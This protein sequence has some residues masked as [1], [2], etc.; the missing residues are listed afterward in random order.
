M[1]GMHVC[2]QGF[3]KRVRDEITFQSSVIVLAI[4]RNFG[5]AILASR[6]A[7]VC[8]RFGPISAISQVL[9]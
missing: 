4:E 1:S 7:G 9:H 3:M 8:S 5:G 2:S 6:I